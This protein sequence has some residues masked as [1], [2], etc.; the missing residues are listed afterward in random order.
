MRP[1]ETP[2]RYAVPGLASA[3]ALSCASTR[4]CG[5]CTACCRVMAVSALGKPAGSPCGHLVSGGCGNYPRRPAACREFDCLWLRDDR[6]VFGDAHRPDRLGLV[7]TDDGDGDGGRT[8][9]AARELEPGAAA[10]PAAVEAI[11]FLRQF[12]EA[13]G[14]P[15]K[16]PARP[17]AAA[18][19]R[20]TIEGGAA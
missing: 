4:S 3:S 18:I 19:C 15:A 1:A 13:R 11:A 10:H 9:V 2:S 16:T 20:L 12:L 8:A 14:V 5:D 7:L 6:G 17:P